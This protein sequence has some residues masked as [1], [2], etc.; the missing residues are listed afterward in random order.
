MPYTDQPLR[1][2]WKYC[3][4]TSDFNIAELYQPKVTLKPG[5]RL[6]AAGSCFAQNIGRY[7]RQSNLEFVDVEPAPANMPEAV[8]KRFGYGLYSARYGNIYTVR[9]LHQLLQD[10]L[11]E[12]IHPC[13]IWQRQGRYFDALRPACEPDGFSSETELRVH[14]LDH[15]RRVRTVFEKAD[16]FVFT[17]GLTEAWT[18]RET[19]VAYPTA[20]GVIAGRFDPAAHEF[21]N[22]ATHET[23]EDLA[24]AISLI[25]QLAP[26]LPILLTVS[27]VPLV[28]T[29]SGRHVLQATTYSKAVL[30]CVAEECANS[31][32]LVDYVP[33]YEIITGTPFM[34]KFYDDNLRTVTAEGVQAVMSVFF[35]AHG[36]PLPSPASAS[37]AGTPAFSAEQAEDDAYCEE[38]LLEAFAD[39]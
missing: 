29:A 17:L 16:A 30:R 13:A 31:D 9:Q 23:S 27:P 14:R 18:D 15:L 12:R 28:A 20:P 3:R 24:L 39:R 38:A 4:E 22:F 10:A 25:R 33:S 7:V 36:L 34:S 8:A 6:A 32:P 19:G 35:A 1:A 26:E 2:F 5:Q 21:V 11:N 37:T